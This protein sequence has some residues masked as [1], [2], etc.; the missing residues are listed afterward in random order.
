MLDGGRVWCFGGE[1]L[2]IRTRVV[3]V[4]DEERLSWENVLAIMR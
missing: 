2:W 3:V 1:G 4:G